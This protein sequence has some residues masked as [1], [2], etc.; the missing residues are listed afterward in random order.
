M[1]STKMDEF[2]RRIERSEYDPKSGPPTTVPTE[3]NIDR[4]NMVIDN[5]RLT[6]NKITNTI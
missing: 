4:V 5:R 2:R 3:E 6:I 1:N